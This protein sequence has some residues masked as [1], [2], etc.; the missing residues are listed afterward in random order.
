MKLF[1]QSIILG[2]SFEKEEVLTMPT[3]S[4]FYGLLIQMFWDDHAPPHFHVMYAE[5]EVSIDIETLKVT[6][7]HMPRRALALVLEWGIR[8]SRRII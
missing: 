7:G 3:I 5:Y 1:S 4:M 2:S 8:A 6:K